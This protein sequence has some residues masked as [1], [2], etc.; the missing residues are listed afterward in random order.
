MF[1]PRYDV[2]VADSDGIFLISE[3]GSHLLRGALYAR[4]A[5]MIDGHRTTSAI[6]DGLPDV[7][8]AAVYYAVNTL[9]EKGYLVD[10]A[11]RDAD[12]D[13]EA[14]LSAAIAAHMPANVA[15]MLAAD[16]LADGLSDYNLRSLD[17]RRSW[18]LLKPTGPVIWLGPLFRPGAT[19]CWE[20]LAHRLRQHRAVETYLRDRSADRA[21]RHRSIAAPPAMRTAIVAALNASAPFEDVV[22][23]LDVRT[24][25]ARRHVVVRRPNCPACG[26]P[27][28]PARTPAAPVLRPQPKRFIAD[29]GHRTIDPDETLRRFGH[30]VSD[31]TGVVSTLTADPIDPDGVLH[32]YTSGRNLALTSRTL[33][34]LRV[35]MRRGASGKGMTDIQA[36]ASGLCEAIER[37]SAVFQGDE[38]RIHASFHQRAGDAIHPSA[39]MLFSDAQYASRIEWNQRHAPA[40][41]IP[42]PF[43]DAALVEWTPVW[44]LTRSTIR[45]LPTSYCYLNYPYREGERTACISTS[46]G[47]AAG[48]TLE[49]AC[50]QGVLELIERDAV[51]L[52]W[53]NRAR[54]PGVALA[55]FD[56]AQIDRL[57]RV[58][59]ERNREVWVLDVT[60]DLG[61]PTFAALSRRIDSTVE[62]I[63]MGFGAHLD[64]RVAVR[65]ALSELNQGLAASIAREQATAEPTWE[66]RDAWQWAETATLAN[67]PHLAPDDTAPHRTRADCGDLANDNLR[68]DVLTCQRSLE[69]RGL[70]VL[71]LDLTRPD[72]GLPVVKVVVPGLRPYFPRFAPGRLFVVPAQL[73]WTG[74]PL[75]EQQLNPV[76]MIP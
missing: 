41:R 2:R 45:Y 70:E 64:A 56:D 19:A 18:M 30:H 62:D 36:R 60:S 7:E 55:T 73:G 48:N 59:A 42:E 23:A 39:C 31:I 25:Q 50:L 47:N 46:T 12:G 22:V 35:N 20:C 67:Q 54:R 75:S 53:Y 13:V 15:V 51:A 76:P 68:D 5:T 17:A 72:V 1:D 71:I 24:Q 32:V 40:N 10:G 34:G 8:A 9:A 33:D 65:R 63:I 29:G 3:H 16:Y 38:P 26:T 28:D 61:I 43:D 57:L 11:R 69:A 49:E 44:S 6:V 14:E 58:Y 74:A 66:E 27:L 4:L 21:V 52:W 37:Y